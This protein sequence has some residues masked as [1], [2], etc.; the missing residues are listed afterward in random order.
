METPGADARSNWTWR[1]GFEVTHH[2]LPS[3]RVN[4]D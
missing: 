2:T 4:V 3:L 1:Q